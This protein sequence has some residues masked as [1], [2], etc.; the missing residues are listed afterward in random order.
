MVLSWLVDGGREFIFE[1][2]SVI[3]EVT[4][5]GCVVSGMGDGA[6]KLK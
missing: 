1:L 2:S 6:R 3:G 5:A 4:C